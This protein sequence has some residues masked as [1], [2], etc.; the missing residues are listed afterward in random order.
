[1]YCNEDNIPNEEGYVKGIKIGISKQIKAVWILTFAVLL[2]YIVY[3]VSGWGIYY[4]RQRAACETM[5]LIRIEAGQ[6]VSDDYEIMLEDC[7]DM[8]DPDAYLPYKLLGMDTWELSGQIN[9]FRNGVHDLFEEFGYPWDWDVAYV[10][11]YPNIISYFFGLFDF[12][13][14]F[15]PEHTVLTNY[16]IFFAFLLLL[17][18]VI[19]TK[20][21]NKKNKLQEIILR[22]D[23][24][25]C[26]LNKKKNVVIPYD[27]ISSIKKSSYRGV[28]I[29]TPGTKVKISMLKNQVEIINKITDSINTLKRVA[30]VSASSPV[31]QFSEN[32]T[33]ILQFKSLLDAG[34]IT[35]EEFERKKKDLLEFDN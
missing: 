10:F 32:T 12:T 17:I 35:Q 22:E 24:V 30:V 26:K 4:I 5:Q 20:E 25:D 28:E 6:K 1:M 16:V 8:L 21:V 19:I 2:C 7:F 9:S 3:V 27:R 15:A 29:K 11:L 23:A 18:C 13:S 31:E 14:K 34:V 33:K